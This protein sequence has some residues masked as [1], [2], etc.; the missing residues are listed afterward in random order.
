MTY[1]SRGIEKMKE[2]E[3]YAHFRAGLVEYSPESFT[4]DELK[5]ILD[6]MIRSKVAIEDH[7]REHF[8]TLTET[9]QTMLLDSLGSSGYK[10]RDWWYRMLI[11]GPVHRSRPT[12]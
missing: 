1:T 3:D 2:L 7:M 12:V 4:I 5:E 9:E 11:D 10:D 8:A 6:D